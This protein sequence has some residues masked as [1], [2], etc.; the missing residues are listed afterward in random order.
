ML[1]TP[2]QPSASGFQKKR[3]Q[4]QKAEVPRHT[5]KGHN[6]RQPQF[7]IVLGTAILQIVHKLRRFLARA[8]S[9]SVWSA[10]S[11]L[12]LSTARDARQREQAP[13]TPNAS[14]SS[15][16]ALPRCV[17]CVFALKQFSRA[18]S[19]PA[20]QAAGRRISSAARCP[21]NRCL[22]CLR[23]WCRSRWL[24]GFGI[25]RRRRRDVRTRAWLL[26]RN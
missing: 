23:V 16:A 14:R 20:P 12:P 25:W 22:S 24:S 21:R 7:S 5:E 10:W 1:Y 6:L 26:A 2:F 8:W 3:I 15:G 17:L 11:L 13:R 9:R 19:R 18:S 4:K